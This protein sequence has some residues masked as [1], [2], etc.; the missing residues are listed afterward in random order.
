[1]KELIT[2]DFDLPAIVDSFDVRG[3]RFTEV[4][5]YIHI[6]MLCSV[7]IN[8]FMIPHDPKT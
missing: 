8:P 7:L 6:C 2:V 3:A 1:M 4:V 5:A